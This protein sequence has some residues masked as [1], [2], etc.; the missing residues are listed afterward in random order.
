MLVEAIIQDIWR[1]NWQDMI[2]LEAYSCR[3]LSRHQD[4][5]YSA[6]LVHQTTDRGCFLPVLSLLG[7][8]EGL[9]M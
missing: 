4:V 2:P 1:S 6:R 8:T 3:D 9:T 7:D 5:R